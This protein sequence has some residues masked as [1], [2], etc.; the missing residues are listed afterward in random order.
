M[1]WGCGQGD[2]GEEIPITF[3]VPFCALWPHITLAGLWQSEGSL[4]PSI[5]Q[6]NWLPRN[7]LRHLCFCV[8]TGPLVSQWPSVLCS[9]LTDIQMPRGGPC[10]LHRV[11]V[12]LTCLMAS[13]PVVCPVLCAVH[14][15]EK[16][17]VIFHQNCLFSYLCPCLICS[18][19]V[20]ASACSHLLPLLCGFVFLVHVMYLHVYFSM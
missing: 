1:R 18:L 7:A 14:R 9:T 19:N 15:L 20:F 3:P 16:Q 13:M 8:G 4:L 2:L 10:F 17:C 6:Q 12:P 5:P 11:G